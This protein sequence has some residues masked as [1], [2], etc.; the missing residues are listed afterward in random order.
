MALL[1]LCACDAQP[2]LRH[3]VA[4]GD[5]ER[6]RAAIERYECVACHAIPGVD[7]PDGIVGPP[8]TA[9]SR[10][11]YI[12][13]SLPNAPGTLVAWLRDPP[14][15]LPGTGMPDLGV[16]EAEA[17]DMAAYLYTLGSPGDPDAPIPRRASVPPE[18]RLAAERAA[19]ALLEGGGGPGIPIERAMEIV[20]SRI[21]AAAQR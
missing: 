4:M 17:R 8:L 6:G 5:A 20:A 12:A 18:D 3:M 14:A 15:I 16:G 13:G 10:R 2:Q 9:F 1:A 7:G 19:A 21:A 11:T